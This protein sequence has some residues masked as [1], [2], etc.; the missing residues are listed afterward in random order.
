M[1]SL[2][3][4]KKDTEVICYIEGANA[5]LG[6]MGYTDHSFRHL[7]IVSNKAFEIMAKL[8]MTRRMAEL[9][10]I[11]GYLHDIGNVVSRYNHS[12]SGALLAA[13]ILT[14]L[15]MDCHELTQ[16]IG[17]IGNHDEG[18]AVAIN[19]IAAALILADKTDVRRSRVRNRDFVTFDIHDRVN[20]AVEESH[21]S[22]I[23]DNKV[24]QLS[25]TI[26]TTISPVMDYF[27]IFLARMLLCKKASSRLNMSFELVIN[28]QKVL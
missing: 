5:H 21:V 2:E 23:N 3:Q 20:Y 26:D 11:A 7:E 14:R 24:F 8:G 13:A 28:G 27:E 6:A 22:I 4:V 16:I 9:A 25:L 1:V 17:A 12:Q 10:G 18:T 19:P 15:G